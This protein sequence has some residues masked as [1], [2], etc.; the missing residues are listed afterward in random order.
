MTTGYGTPLRGAPRTAF[1]GCV[2]MLGEHGILVNDMLRIMELVHFIK[3]HHAEKLRGRAAS[4][5]IIAGTHRNK[6][7]ARF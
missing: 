4:T 5:L 2:G 1:Q 3:T 7:N 6:I